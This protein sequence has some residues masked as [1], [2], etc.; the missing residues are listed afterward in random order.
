MAPGEA[1]EPVLL[2][3]DTAGTGRDSR[4]GSPSWSD[5][6]NARWVERS[7][8]RST[9]VHYPCDPCCHP[10]VAPRAPS[11]VSPYRMWPHS[12][13]DATIWRRILGFEPD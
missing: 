10:A 12:P 7:A 8:S 9:H 1:A 6:R 13:V 11:Q 4:T 3:W 2:H 5:H